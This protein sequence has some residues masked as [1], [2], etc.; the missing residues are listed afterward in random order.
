MHSFITLTMIYNVVLLQKAILKSAN[1]ALVANQSSTVKFLFSRK[2]LFIP[3]ASNIFKLQV[4][5]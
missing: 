2:N 1:T 4:N 5:Y 3:R